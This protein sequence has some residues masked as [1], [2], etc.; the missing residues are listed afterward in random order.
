MTLPNAR[1]AVFDER[2]RRF[3]RLRDRNVFIYWPHGLGD[4]AHLAVILPFFDR[5]N[6]YAIGRYGDDYVALMEAN[7]YARP[8]YTGIRAISDGSQYGMRHLGLNW[9]HIDAGKVYRISVPLFESAFERERFDAL[10]YT[11]YPER[12]GRTAFPFHTKARALLRD[13]V[14]LSA[15]QLQQ[16]ER[17][18]RS[19]LSFEVDAALQAGVD[20]RLRQ[21]TGG[22]SRLALLVHTGHTAERKNW[23]DAQAQRF[24][25][26]ASGDGWRV[27][28]FDRDFRSLLGDIDAPFAKILKALVRRAHLVA[29]VPTGPLHVA[30]AY[31]KV[32]V[33]GIWLAHH[34]DWYEERSDCA[35]HLLGETTMKR[36]YDRRAA[37][38]ELPEALRNRT[39]AF[40]SEPIDA[41][42]V[43]QAAR[44]L[45]R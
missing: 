5:S 32:P 4:W 27:L 19:S 14:D 16:L 17:P 25:D 11:D 23:D 24:C 41:A 45:L 15:A 37:T 12:D 38:A 18:L 9:K 44:E 42:G 8:V 22:S 34:P 33:V 39:V 3:A 26:L 2:R 7:A 20:R 21:F 36:R 6:R 1:I 40:S 30:L 29:G 43:W 35:T 31:A 13:L 10:L 28:R